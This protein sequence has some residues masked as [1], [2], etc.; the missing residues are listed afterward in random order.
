MHTFLHEYMMKSKCVLFMQPEG[1]MQLNELKSVHQLRAQA[2]KLGNDEDAMWHSMFDTFSLVCGT[3]AAPHCNPSHH[4][5][6][7]EG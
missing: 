3:L 1:T 2:L 7:L 6:V 5:C 4:T